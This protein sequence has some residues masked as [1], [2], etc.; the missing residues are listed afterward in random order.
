MT[1]LLF[2]PIFHRGT[3]IIHI[4]IVNNKTPKYFLFLGVLYGAL[5]DKYGP[6]WIGLLGAS[7]SSVSLFIS[8][9]ASSLTYLVICIGAVKGNFFHIV[10]KIQSYSQREK[11]SQSLH[12]DR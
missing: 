4:R 3:V 7:L 1:F 8:F 6:K 5:T 2:K 11:H 9:W 10:L 12:I